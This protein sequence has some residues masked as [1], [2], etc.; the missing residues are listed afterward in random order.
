MIHLLHSSARVHPG[1]DR[2]V[3]VGIDWLIGMHDRGPLITT[4]YIIT[5]SIIRIYAIKDMK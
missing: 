2:G 5:H 4:D 1:G 3:R